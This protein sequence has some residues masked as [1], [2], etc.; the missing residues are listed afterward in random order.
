MRLLEDGEE[1]N[2]FEAEQVAGVESDCMGDTD[3]SFKA[4][5]F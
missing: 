3:P 4:A 2:C 1:M 5:D